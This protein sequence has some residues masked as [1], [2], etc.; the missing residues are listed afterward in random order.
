MA[1]RRSFLLAS[2]M[3]AAGLGYSYHRGL[4]Y[5]RLSLEPRALDSALNTQ[6]AQLRLT[7]LVA[8][9]QRSSNSS[10]NFTLRAVTPTP[11][12]H[13]LTQGTQLE[14]EINNVLPNA[15][16]RVQTQAK[17]D[18]QEQIDG[19][20]RRLKISSKSH[21][22]ITLSWEHGLDDGFDFAVIGDTGGGLELDW[23]LN[24]AVELGAQFLLHLGDFNY[25]AGEYD[26]AI[27]Q[28]H[29]APL[30][31]YISLGNHDFND[32]GLMYHRFLAELGPLNAHFTVAGT[33]FINIDTAA[34]FFPAQAGLRGD[35]LQRLAKVPSSVENTLMFSH[36]PLR[37]PR[38]ND[39]HEVGGINEV[40]WLLSM[41]NN[42]NTS[43]YLCGHVHHSAE[44][45]IGGLRQWTAGEGLGHEDLI[46]QRQV[47][48][49]L[50]GRVEI[51]RAVAYRWQDLSM[52]WSMHTSPTHQHKLRRDQRERQWKWYSDTHLA[53]SKT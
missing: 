26:R 23:C 2:G 47:A 29:H 6:G 21:D 17:S 46:H 19:I 18:I 15:K 42:L 30:P 1:S 40:A 11:S 50:L 44:L 22:E 43:D 9:K 14:V 45:D 38:P 33:R 8:I 37:D 20:N 28:F 51:G 27:H 3:A 4:R 10:V 24:R 7:D 52:P 53:M 48:Q 35:M 13:L 16:L 39:D 41:A 31:C 36:S 25:T 5:P 32:S 12:L 49:L 34:D